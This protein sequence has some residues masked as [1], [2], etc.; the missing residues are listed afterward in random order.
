MI[1]YQAD[2]DLNANIIRAVRRMEPE[3]EF[4][5]ATEAGL[6]GVPD[7]DVLILAADA[8]RILVSHDMRTMP[9]HFAEHIMGRTSPGVIILPQSLPIREA[10]ENL[11]LIWAATKAEEWVNRIFLLSGE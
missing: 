11:V 8:G 3:I 7:S 1:R 10:A 9:I 2:A 4:K 6:E 5:T